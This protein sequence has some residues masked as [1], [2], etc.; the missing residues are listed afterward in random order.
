MMFKQLNLFCDV[1]AGISS[2]Y[3]EEPSADPGYDSE[4]ERRLKAQG[5]ITEVPDED[6]EVLLHSGTSGCTVGVDALNEKLLLSERNVYAKSNQ[7]MMLRIPR[8]DF[9]LH[10]RFAFEIEVHF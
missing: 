9:M 7:V 10:S 8:E 2:D 1:M 3:V 4:L 5:L 6:A